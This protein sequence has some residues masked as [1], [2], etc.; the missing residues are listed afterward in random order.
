LFVDYKKKQADNRLMLSAPMSSQLAIVDPADD[1]RSS[2][3]LTAVPQLAEY[4]GQWRPV[5][6]GLCHSVWQVLP[7][8]REAR[9]IACA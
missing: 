4:N 2:P 3:L 8:L 7:Y 9:F 5:V 6:G 1:P